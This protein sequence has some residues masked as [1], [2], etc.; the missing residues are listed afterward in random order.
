MGALPNAGTLGAGSPAQ[1]ASPEP[2][3]KNLTTPSM[4]QTP[5]PAGQQGRKDPQLNK[6]Q[7]KRDQNDARGAPSRGSEQNLPG[8][9]Q[10]SPGR[11]SE[12]PPHERGRDRG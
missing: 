6:E 2:P 11:Q 3:T 1:R 12:T 9:S 5:T 4:S 10:Q 7:E 8:V